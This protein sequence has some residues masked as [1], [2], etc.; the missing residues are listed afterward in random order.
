MEKLVVP[1]SAKGLVDLDA[2]IADTCK[3]V[4]KCLNRSVDQLVVTV[5]ERERHQQIIADLRA[6]GARIKLIGDGDLSAGITAVVKDTNV[7][8]VVGTGGAP[9]GVITA[10]AVKCLGGEILGR[11]APKNDAE[12]ER[13]EQMG[14]D[15]NKVM[16]TDDMAPGENIVFLASG[17]TKGDLLDGVR[18]MGSGVRVDSMMVNYASKTVRFVD[19]IHL[20]QHE[21]VPVRRA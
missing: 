7:H 4:A 10:A 9:E 17:V 2:P 3:I 18:F 12:R 20:T 1:Q 15:W 6:V 14:A 13:C 21:G 16:R 19:S 8:M 11:L 5:L